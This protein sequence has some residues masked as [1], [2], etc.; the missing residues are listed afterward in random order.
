[1]TKGKEMLTRALKRYDNQLSMNRVQNHT[2]RMCIKWMRRYRPLM[3]KRF[4]TLA[5][6][7]EEELHGPSSD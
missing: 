4:L 5:K 2:Q 7:R 3:V 6:V 1:M